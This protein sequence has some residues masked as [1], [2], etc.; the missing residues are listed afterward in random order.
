MAL[1]RALA[2]VPSVIGKVRHGTGPIGAPLLLWMHEGSEFSI[3]ELRTL[4]I[5]PVAGEATTAV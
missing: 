5:A 4:M 1:S 2:V 3:R